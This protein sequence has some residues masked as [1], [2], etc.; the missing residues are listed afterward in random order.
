M[1][2][3]HPAV[4]PENIERTGQVKSQ[5]MFVLG[6]RNVLCEYD[7]EHWY[8]HLMVGRPAADNAMS[9]FNA[10]AEFAYDMD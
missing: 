9:F 3:V 10:L 8:Q 7:G 5:E 6:H 2:G 4:V 1:I